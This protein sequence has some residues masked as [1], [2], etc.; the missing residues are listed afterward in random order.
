VGVKALNITSKGLRTALSGDTLATAATARRLRKYKFGAEFISNV[1]PFFR[2]G[3]NLEVGDIVLFDLN[4]LNI[5]DIKEGGTRDGEARLFQIDNK[6]IDFKTGGVSL[7]LVDTNFDKDAR[8]GTISPSSEIAS[9]TDGTTFV[10]QESF[11][12]VFG[13]NEFKKWENLI[14]ASI[15]V[16]NSTYSVDGNA[17]LK[18]LTGNTVVLESALGF[19]PSTSEIMELDIYD[20]QPEDVK[21]VYAFWSDGNFADAGIPYQFF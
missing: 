2:T 3:F 10:I 7:T 11:S 14:G 8:F 6:I 19:T 20:N 21:L 15:R 1:K 13:I 12:S 9:A 17:I 18:S 5:S 4:S 16:H